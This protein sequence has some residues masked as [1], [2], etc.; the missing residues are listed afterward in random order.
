MTL[1]PRRR[2]RSLAEIQEDESQQAAKKR[3]LQQQSHGDSE[4]SEEDANGSRAEI[5]TTS[6]N[7]AATVAAKRGNDDSV[8]EASSLD[9][10]VKPAS[11]PSPPDPSTLRSTNLLS[12]FSKVAPG[13]RPTPPAAPVVENKPAVDEKKGAAAEAIPAVVSA[14]KALVAPAAGRDQVRSTAGPMG[15]SKQLAGEDDEDLKKEE[16]EEEGEEEDA[17]SSKDSDREEE[18]E[19]EE[20]EDVESAASGAL[21][22]AET[23]ASARGA[24]MEKKTLSKKKAKRRD[25]DEDE[26]I[27]DDDD[28]G[29]GSGDVGA[30]A[31]VGQLKTDNSLYHGDS[32]YD[33]LGAATWKR[34]EPVPY[35][36]LARVFDRLETSPKRL[37]KITLISDY[38]RT[39]IAT[40]PSQLLPSVY[41]CINELA[42][43][44]EGLETGVGTQTLMKAV[45]EAT[46]STLAKVQERVKRVGD[47]GVVASE[48]RQLQRTM[49]APAPLT[50]GSVYKVRS[51]L[52]HA[53]RALGAALNLTRCADYGH[54]AD[55][56]R[57]SD[58]R[59]RQFA[60]QEEGHHQAHARCLPRVRDQVYCALFAGQPAHW[61]QAKHSDQGF[62]ARSRVDATG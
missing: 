56:A 59:G 51:G 53:V 18:D 5:A 39:V 15:K 1:Q 9:E 4:R 47:L 44:F 60:D 16:E 14:D 38:F 11:R 13:S 8:A 45:A 50:V 30:G 40:S 28:G 6:D 41:L 52:A 58:H 3:R 19:E 23:D 36:F 37:D 62:N 61:P 55:D 57:A 24:A 32:D 29:G 31:A 17:E 25:A 35:L 48:S 46:G 34:G 54:F 2:L 7:P 26:A 21:R 22:N 27:S 10:R 12:F 43:A 20:E 42:P 33:P 49:F